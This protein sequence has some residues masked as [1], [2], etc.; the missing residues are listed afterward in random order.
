MSSK[1]ALSP[2]ARSWLAMPAFTASIAFAAGIALSARIGLPAYD[3]LYNAVCIAAIVFC[4]LALLLTNAFPVRLLTFA[5]A[6]FACAS[7][8]GADEAQTYQRLRMHAPAGR[9]ARYCARLVSLPRTTGGQSV[10]IASLTA[11]IEDGDTTA[12]GHIKALCTGSEPPRQGRLILYGSPRIPSPA[13]NP[14]GFDE[15]RYMRSRGLWIRMRVDSLEQTPCRSPVRRMATVV[16]DAAAA[17]FARARC[18]RN[19]A[20][21]YA[22]VLGHKRLLTE[23]TR[24]AFRRAGIYHLLAISG[25]HVGLLAGGVLLALGCLPLPRPVRALAAAAVLWGYLLIVGPIPSLFRAVVMYSALLAGLLSRRKH[26]ALN[27]LGLAAIIWL[28]M[29]PT[30]LFTPGFQLSFAATLGIIILGPNIRRL[31]TPPERGA[32]TNLFVRPLAIAFSISLAGFVATAP[33]LLHHFGSISIIGLIANAG[34]VALMTPVMAGAFCG[35]FAQ[36][37]IPPLAA[38]AIGLA[39]TG[40]HAITWLAHNASACWGAFDRCAAPPAWTSALLALFLI[41]FAACPPRRL[42]RFLL[43]SGIALFALAPLG[44]LLQ[45]A[46]PRCEITAFSSSTPVNGV[47]FPNGKLW[48]IGLPPERVYDS[49]YQWV[50][51]PWMRRFAGARL[52]ALV[53]DRIG[54]NIIHD[55]LPYLQHQ[56]P[57]LLIAA[58]ASTDLQTRSDLRALLA[59][60]PTRLVAAPSGAR[61]IPSPQCTCTIYHAGNEGILARIS[62]GQSAALIASASGAVGWRDT[63]CDYRIQGSK[64]YFGADSLDTQ[65]SGA[66]TAILDS[67][68]AAPRATITASACHDPENALTASASQATQ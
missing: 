10:Y 6:G 3:P 1:R 42:H 34:A 41:G 53:I 23:E 33:L 12:L 35:V 36:L 9:L 24:N 49:P 66:I 4:F 21:L 43:K 32:I 31:A 54:P 25:L 61:F 19:E 7:L 16:R 48:L 37:W 30:S 28:A 58:D 44:L 15:R 56:P 68:A 60:Y 18:R 51:S 20:I 64:V 2:A 39:E 46:N 38:P 11:R 55:L 40:L 52:D 29:S 14:G 22:T 59:H 62:R 45:G 5:A 47:R 50:L 13:R 65:S 17:A 27:A 26:Y 8:A 63:V 67:P 57:A